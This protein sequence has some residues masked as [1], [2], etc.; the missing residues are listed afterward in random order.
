MTAV[1]RV[2]GLTT[3]LVG[4]AA[5]WGAGVRR[6]WERGGWLGLGRAVL[7]TVVAVMLA[8]IGMAV[9]ERFRMWALWRRIDRRMRADRALAL[10]ARER[11]GRT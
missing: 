8:R 11:G 1:G 4:S 2:W 5:L 10:S 7:W 9:R 3:L 6:S